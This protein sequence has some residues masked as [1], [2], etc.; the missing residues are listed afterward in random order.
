MFLHVGLPKIFELRTLL[1]VSA[2]SVEVVCGCALWALRAVIGLVPPELEF[3]EV[4]S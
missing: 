3:F 1:V 4:L 2:A